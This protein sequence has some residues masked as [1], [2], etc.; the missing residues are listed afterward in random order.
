MSALETQDHVRRDSGPQD[1]GGRQMSAA[2]LVKLVAKR[3]IVTKLHDKTY[4]VS[5]GV[6]IV[7]ILAVVGFN[8]VANSGNNDY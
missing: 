7:I 8:V 2:N 6:F 4:L 3:E 5:M 1:P